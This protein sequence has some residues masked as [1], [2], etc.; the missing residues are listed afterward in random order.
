M[1]PALFYGTGVVLDRL[2]GTV[3]RCLDQRTVLGERLDMAFDTLGF[4]VAPLVG[5]VW[6]RLPVWYLSIPAARCLFRLGCWARRSRGHPVKDTPGSRVGRPAA[7]LQIVF[8]AAALS[9]VAL[10]AL[11]RPAAIIVTLPSL[12]VFLRDYLAVTRG[13]RKA[14]ANGI[15]GLS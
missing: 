11:V 12:A 2:G 3:A 15:S 7:A 5:V 9:P 4:I 14:K 10:A 8:I 6:G 13:F 1:S